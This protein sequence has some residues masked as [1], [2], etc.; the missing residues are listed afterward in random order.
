[1]GSK[2]TLPSCMNNMDIANVIE[3]SS[4]PVEPIEPASPV[5]EPPPGIYSIGTKLRWK[6]DNDNY[7]IA[8]I[9]K[10]GLL[11]VKAS[12]ENKDMPNIIGISYALK[13]YKNDIEWF[14]SFEPGGIVSVEPYE[15]IAEKKASKAL[16]DGSDADKFHELHRRYNSRTIISMGKSPLERLAIAKDCRT[17][18]SKDIEYWT[19][20]CASNTDEYNSYTP[21][22]VRHA[23]KTHFLLVVDGKS[24]EVASQITMKYRVNTYY[25][26]DI[27]TGILYTNF[28]DIGNCLGRNGKPMLSVVY[29]GERIHLGDLF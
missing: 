6:K 9:T 17:Y 10:N 18:C 14:A 3:P 20:V 27:M 7:R 24:R 25:I 8:V 15:T 28:K 12:T 19:N 2:H 23:G 1:M 29:R 26:V 11:Q 5:P 16:V 22:Y 4:L 13:Y 21:S